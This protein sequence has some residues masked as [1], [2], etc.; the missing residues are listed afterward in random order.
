MAQHSLS[1][2]VIRWSMPSVLLLSA[3]AL[4]RLTLASSEVGPVRVTH[5]RPN[6][7]APRYNEPRV[8]TDEQLHRV[9]ARVRPRAEQIDT[10]VIVHALRLWGPEVRFDDP[11][12]LDGPTML[13]YFLDDATYR[14]L[15]GDDA[16][17]L[18]EMV[19]D[20]LRTRLRRSDGLRPRLAA[21]H[22]DDLLATLA[23]CGVPLDTP[24]VTRDGTYQVADLL[25]GSMRRF[26]RTQQEY[27][28][29]AI[30]FAR[31]LFPTSRWHNRFGE[32][33]DV[34]EMVAELVEQSPPA[35]VC[36]GT[37]R[38]EALV[39][40]N[41]ADEASGALPR[42]TRRNILKH[43][44]RISATL[45]QTQATEGSW[46]RWW[47]GGRPTEDSP[48]DRSLYTKILVTGHQLEWLAFAP[49]EVQPP[50]ENIVRAGQW[51]VRAML[52]IED[53]QLQEHF[54]PLSHAARAL[55]LWRGKEPADMWRELEQNGN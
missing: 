13:A 44:G 21:V 48:E 39:V 27:E 28:W 20:G 42:A 40:L 17:P 33:L 35:G 6:V 4:Y 9:L 23:E 51:L 38:L 26:H 1:L 8:A 14:R 31:Y 7:I 3:C 5:R 55:C 18:F 49:P 54:G 32:P 46:D 30:S 2:N 41:R 10:N 36:A 24:L 37:H 53:R 16:P 29:T 25:E 34:R 12:W 47:A 11:A 45:Q 52:E 15:A 50:R 22:E 43:L 19:P